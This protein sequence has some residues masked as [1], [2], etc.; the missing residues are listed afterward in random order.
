M[1]RVSGEAGKC[2]RPEEAE[3]GANKA[4]SVRP[5][6][7]PPGEG[8]REHDVDQ[9]ALQRVV[10]DT[11]RLLIRDG[12]AGEQVAG[13]EERKRIVGFSSF[14]RAPFR[15]DLPISALFRRLCPS[16]RSLLASCFLRCQKP[17]EDFPLP[18][19]HLPLFPS[20]LPHCNRKPPQTSSS[21]FRPL[22]SSL[23]SLSRSRPLPPSNS[24]PSSPPHL[25][26]SLPPHQHFTT[27]WTTLRALSKVPALSVDKSR[28]SAVLP[29]LNTHS[30]SFSAHPPTRSS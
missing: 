8:E 7:S 2:F 17:S 26:P 24:S 16:R 30:I 20:S 13:K 9:R 28:S 11:S 18:S 23:A 22:L 6:I 4:K 10:A 12:R 15:R 19:P 27:Q 29:A 21:R 14:V 3:E 1:R 5:F 25:P